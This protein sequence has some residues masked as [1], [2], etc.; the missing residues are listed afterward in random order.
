MALFYLPN[1]TLRDSNQKH[2][3]LPEVFVV[4]ITNT[5]VVVEAIGQLSNPTEMLRAITEMTVM[6]PWPILR[7][8]RESRGG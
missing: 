1:I 7:I 2:P 3:R 8:L 6:D 5:T 4:F